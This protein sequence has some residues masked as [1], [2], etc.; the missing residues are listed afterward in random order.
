MKGHRASEQ[1]QMEDIQEELQ[2]KVS[3]LKREKEK[4]GDQVAFLKYSKHRNEHLGPHVSM[5]CTHKN[6]QMYQK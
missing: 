4:L 3:Q 2:K 5:L 1:Q 6:V